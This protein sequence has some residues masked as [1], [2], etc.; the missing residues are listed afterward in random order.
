MK[1][2]F[3]E[4]IERR[5]TNSIKY[6]MAAFGKLPEAIPLWV[7]DMDFKTA[8]CIINALQERC[9]H[10]IF[11]YSGIDDE[12]KETVSKWFAARHD[13]SIEHDWLVLAPGV[14]TAI[15]TAV[16]A[17]TSPGEAI[18]INQ[19]VYGPFASS[20]EQSGRKLVV[21][22]LVYDNETY[23]IDFDDFEAKIKQENVKMFIL[24]N[25]HNPVGRVWAE[26]ELEKL[27]EI[28]LKHGVLVVSDEIHQDFVYD[29]HKHLV[30]ANLNPNFADIAITCTAPTKT[31]NIAGLSVSNILITN[32]D[33]RA[34]FK[35]EYSKSGLSQIGIMGIVA[36]QAAYSGGADW[37]DQLNRYIW[38]NIT[39]IDNFLK[40]RIP[41]VKC[42]RTEGTF[43]VWLDFKDLGLS[44]AELDELISNK[45]QLWLNTGISFGAGGSGFMRLNAGTTRSTLHMAMER[46]K[47][48]ITG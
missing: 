4:T 36:C 48:A 16:R 45:A 39:Y 10:G 30:F 32:K 2:D 12:Y 15:Y 25:P 31:F 20:V 18:I 9:D 8:P 41:C 42:V 33:L 14:V 34:T 23:M 1:F 19:P 28:C 7:A 27:G 38:G 26:E 47:T 13:W 21:N 29:G 17:F 22:E 3:D 6:G 24:C 35:S 43:L 5:N 46:L 44:D 11:G 37:L 40:E